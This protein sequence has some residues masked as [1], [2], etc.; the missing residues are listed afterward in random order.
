[1][2]ILLLTLLFATHLS[3][4]TVEVSRSF[5]DD[6]NRAFIE[7][8]ASRAVI[9][10]DARTIVALTDADKSKA[11]LIEILTAQN[12]DLAKLK[13]EKTSYF[14]GIVKTTRCR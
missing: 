7:L 10:A 3:A 6:A 1:M 11:Q 4:Q 14:F 13:C 9:E 2:K 8:R 5:L 12:A